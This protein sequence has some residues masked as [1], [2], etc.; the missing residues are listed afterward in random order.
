MRSANMEDPFFR[1]QYSRRT[2]S[3][4][5]QSLVSAY[6]SR[7]RERAVVRATCRPDRYLHRTREPQCRYEPECHLLLNVR[8]M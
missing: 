7:E 6:C 1:A 4:Y 5:L 8:L 3:D 2:K